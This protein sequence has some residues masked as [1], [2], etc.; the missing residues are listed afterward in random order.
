V[1]V[2]RAPAELDIETAPGFRDELGIVLSVGEGAT[3]VVDMTE[4]A[5]I[6]SSGMGA[7]VAVAKLA[8][9]RH[10]ALA[11]RGVRPPVLTALRL[12]SL[13]DVLDASVEPAR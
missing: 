1:L 10:G 12:A 2:V 8:G 9:E 3:L 13:V 4:T 6:D 7:L 11:L 5:F